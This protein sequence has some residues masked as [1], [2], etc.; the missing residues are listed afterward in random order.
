M[1]CFCNKKPQD[2]EKE[3]EECVMSLSD[4]LDDVSCGLNLRFH[5]EKQGVITSVSHSV[6]DTFFK[7]AKCK[8]NERI[9]DVFHG[10]EIK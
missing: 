2:Q 8:L 4:I 5:G 3:K 9:A 1:T 7:V 6:L 10:Y